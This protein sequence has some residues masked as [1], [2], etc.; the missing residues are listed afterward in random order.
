MKGRLSIGSLLAIR[1][2]LIANAISLL[3]VGVLY[4]VYGA[5]PAGL[6][7]GGVVVSAAVALLCCVPLT[8]P[9]RTKR[10]ARR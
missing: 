8:D 1:L 3:A 7:V 9:Y 2:L 5:R 10:K 6:I 4:L